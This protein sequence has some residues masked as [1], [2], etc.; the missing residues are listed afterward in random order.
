MP[1]QGR[2]GTENM[3]SVILKCYRRLKMPGSE[4][5]RMRGVAAVMIRDARREIAGH[6]DV[7]ARGI[8][9]ASDDIDGPHRHAY[10]CVP[11]R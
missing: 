10:R 5:G 7:A 4:L 6:A 3:S 9:F 8:L 1:P 11:L 2:M